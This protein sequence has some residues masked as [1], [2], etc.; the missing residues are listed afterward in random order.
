VILKENSKKLIFLLRIKKFI[1]KLIYFIGTIVFFLIILIIGY[2]Y[3]SGMHERFKPVPLI[4][5]IDKVILDKYLGFSIFEIDEYIKIKF[6]SLKYIFIDNEFENVVIKID[7]KNIYNLELQRK[8]KIKNI[9]TD[10]GNFSKAQLETKKKNYDIK[11]RVKGDRVLHWYDKDQTSYK[12]DLKGDK[13]I[14]GLE[15]FSVQKPITRNYIYEFIFHK[16]LEF[17]KL[18]SLKYFF[19]NLSLNDSDQ[20]I[21]AVEEGFSKELIERNKKR[22]G[23]IFGL[24]ESLGTV[25]PNIEYDL[26]SKEYWKSNHPKL[27]EVALL[28][29]YKLKHKKLNINEIFDLEKWATFFAVVDLSHT[30][31]G[32]LSKSVKLY[33]NPVTAKF[34]P[35]GFDGHYNPNLFN[36]FLILDFMDIENI[37]CGYICSDREWYLKFF[38]NNDGSN[39][40]EFLKLYMKALKKISSEEFI[41]NFNK[42]YFEEIKKNNYQLQ[43]EISKK[44]LNYYKGL[45]L[46]I[47]DKNFLSTR[48]K[49]IKGRINKYV[50]KNKAEKDIQYNINK[51]LDILKNENVKYL[52]GEHYL[53]KDLIIEKNYYLSKNEKLN[54]EQG[55]KIFFKKDATIFSEGTIFFNG[56]KE[57]PILIYS[58]QKIGSL[59]LTNNNYNFNNVIFKNLSFPKDINKILYGGINIINSNLTMLNVE[60]K[61]SNSE[62]AINIVSS[63]SYIKNLTISDTSADAIDLDFGEL[64]FENITCKN[65]FNDCLD[66]SGVKVKGK[67]FRAINIKDKGISF[68]ENST[69]SLS[70]ANFINNKLAVA[71]KDGSNLSLSNYNLKN[72]KYDI[73]VFNK[74]KE[75]EGSR[76]NLDIINEHKRLNILL[77]INNEI[78]S[79]SAQKIKKMKNNYI[80]SLFY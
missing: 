7:Q 4:K 28:Q 61:N 78:I 74:K 36:D 33:Y 51:P 17:N 2:Y 42:K 45:G 23:P 55:V 53:A 76:L 49:Y 20:G 31:H 50:Q 75:Y 52:N 64:V 59:V 6:I 19:I 73:A 10:L 38:K 16:L 30:M 39:N 25:Y 29:L 62:D 44:D 48:A 58:N 60:I 72:N 40:Y 14:W 80:N 5:K 68:G 41:N 56:S 70:E 77:G 21:Y 24:E 12:I 63:K 65:I 22:N 43:S 11:I 15:E 13:R 8:N 57:K 66:V 35:I 37:N 54:I 47:F 69:G 71:V 26:Y 32:S 27:T 46:Y 34:E 79:S 18:I 67:Q 3:T 9:T 1:S